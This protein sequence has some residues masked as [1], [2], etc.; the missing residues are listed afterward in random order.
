QQQHQGEDHPGLEIREHHRQNGTRHGTDDELPFRADVPVVGAEADRKPDGDQYE[1]CRLYR[2]LMQRPGLVQGIDK[3]VVERLARVLAKREKQG[4]TRDEG[5]PQRNEG[6]KH[7]EKRRA[8][9]PF[10]ELDAHH[11]VSSSG[12]P[13]VASGRAPPMSRPIFSYV[14]SAMGTGV[15]SLPPC[16]TAMA[17]QISNNSP[18]S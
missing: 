5:K 4:G 13:E 18:R 14:A 10:D 1:G 3:I 15:E 9:R 11:T 2:Q 17:S 7:T 12:S 6:R 8:L 16:M